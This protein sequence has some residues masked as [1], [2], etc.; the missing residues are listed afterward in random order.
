MLDLVGCIGFYM[1]YIGCYKYD[2][3]CN[4]LYGCVHRFRF[5]FV[6]VLQASSATQSSRQTWI[7]TREQRQSFIYVFNRLYIVI[8]VVF[9]G[10]VLVLI[11]FIW[12]SMWFY[13]V[14]CRF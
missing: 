12:V 14:F 9:I 5:G 1:C 7:G 4:E 3:D 8:K 11:G 2:I 6:Y 13:N 10:V